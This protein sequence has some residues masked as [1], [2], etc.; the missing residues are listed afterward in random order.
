MFQLLPRVST[1]SQSSK[2][3]AVMSAKDELKRN[4]SSLLC[5]HS[6]EN[7]DSH[8][9]RSLVILLP[10]LY[11]TERAIKKYC[12]VYHQHNMDV[13]VVDVKLKHFVLPSKGRAA[14]RSILSTLAQH[15]FMQKRQDI[16]IH[17]FSIGT[18]MYNVMLHEMAKQP[19]KYAVFRDK[20]RGLVFDSITIGSLD[21]MSAGVSRRLRNPVGQF[22]LQKLINLYFFITKCCTV[23]AYSDLQYHFKYF[24]LHIPSLFFYCKNDPM[25]CEDSIQQIIRLWRDGDENFAGNMVVHE[26]CWETSLHAGHL[27]QYPDEYVSIL[28]EFL[29]SL[30]LNQTDSEVGKTASSSID[31]NFESTWL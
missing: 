21:R 31:S 12:D 11:A 15:D 22:L 3:D 9:D 6:A 24:P 10:W 30:R 18:Y 20:I 2:C 13:L 7:R 8:T 27:K 29:Q 23:R 25:S 26:K 1:T 5:L 19:E 14:A 16:V 28:S 17:S 4:I